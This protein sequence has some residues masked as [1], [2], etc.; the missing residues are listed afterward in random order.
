MG[1]MCKSEGRFDLHRIWDDLSDYCQ[2]ILV[3]AGM[4]G[5]TQTRPANCQLLYQLTDFTLFRYALT[6]WP[7]LELG[8]EH[9][10][11]A[12]QS[13]RPAPACNIAAWQLL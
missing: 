5:E 6:R 11:Q 9:L 3:S 8:I 1:I 12:W 2:V 4:S 7:S 10:V 13:P